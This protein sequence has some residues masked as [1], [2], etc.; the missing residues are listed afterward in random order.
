MEKEEVSVSWYTTEE[1]KLYIFSGD[2]TLIHFLSI[3][4][5]VDIIT[6]LVKAFKDKNLW[7]RKSMFGFARKL[8]IFLIIIV[9]NIIDHLIGMGG[10]LLM[11]TVIFYI[12]N[13]LM[14]IIENV[15][16]LGVKLPK[17]LQKALKVIQETDSIEKYSDEYKNKRESENN[18]KD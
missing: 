7:S 4:M 13:E 15:T 6:G 2:I 17:D 14:S 3:L 10:A 18:G 11:A 16:Q 9:S 5:A 8:L 1:F 12:A